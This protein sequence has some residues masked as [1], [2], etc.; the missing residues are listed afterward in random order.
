MNKNLKKI[1]SNL[2]HLEQTSFVN[3]TLFYRQSFDEKEKKSLFIN[4][5]DERNYLKQLD[6]FLSI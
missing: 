2:S 3:R 5:S 1:E 4:L 6:E